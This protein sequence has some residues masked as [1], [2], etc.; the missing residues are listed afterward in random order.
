M[1]MLAACA[2]KKRH[3]YKER[4]ENTQNHFSPPLPYLVLSH[5]AFSTTPSPTSLRPSFL[6]RRVAQRAVGERTHLARIALVLALVTR[7]E[8]SAG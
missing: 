6:Q 1:D 2:A 8:I 7:Q 5:S 3:V 4:F